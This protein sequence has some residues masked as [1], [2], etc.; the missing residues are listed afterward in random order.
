MSVSDLISGKDIID[1]GRTFGNPKVVVYSDLPKNLDRNTGYFVLYEIKPN[2]GHW[3]LLFYD[4]FEKTWNFF[5]SYGIILDKELD[6][7]Y[8]PTDYKESKPLTNLI[9]GNGFEEYY[10]INDI[11]YQKF[12]ENINTCGKWCLI[13]YLCY[14]LGY[15]T[16]WFD[17]KFKY[18]N[19]YKLN[20]LFN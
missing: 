20:N 18:I 15:D 14:K 16:E 2:D 19:D 9:F 12:K 13:R 4:K 17:K 11:P 5:D 6:F 8:Y 3:T 1:I 7:T 10:E